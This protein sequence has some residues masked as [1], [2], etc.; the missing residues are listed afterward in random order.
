MLNL[1]PTHRKDKSAYWLVAS[2][3]VNFLNIGYMLLPLV[4]LYKMK[5]SKNIVNVRKCTYVIWIL[6]DPKID[7]W[8][9]SVFIFFPHSLS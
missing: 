4:K 2:S 6:F 8:I 5:K 1:L 3:I 9:H 7:R